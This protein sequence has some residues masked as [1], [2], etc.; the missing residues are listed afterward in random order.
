VRLRLP[1]GR[2][3]TSRASA[4]L[5]IFALVWQTL[6]PFASL[7]AAGS[8]GHV[9][10]TT[11]LHS[12]ALPGDSDEES[13]GGSASARLHC[14]FCIGVQAQSIEHDLQPVLSLAPGL[15]SS[16]IVA[17]DAVAAIL[18]TSLPPPSRG[19]PHSS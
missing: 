4:W 19:P 15:S 18:V 17:R 16:H 14:G 5:A 6:Q 12:L 2:D 8:E 7:A 1:R 13:K 11:G 3:R 9:C 10:P